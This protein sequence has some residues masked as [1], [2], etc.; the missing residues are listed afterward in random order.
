MSP[1]PFTESKNSSEK[2]KQKKTEGNV[3]SKLKYSAYAYVHTFAIGLDGEKQCFQA[4]RCPVRM[5]GKVLF[6]GHW[7][8][9]DNRSYMKVD[10]LEFHVNGYHPA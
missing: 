7:R 3:M 8:K 6:N 10:G 9:T 1:I 4:I 2:N 5:D